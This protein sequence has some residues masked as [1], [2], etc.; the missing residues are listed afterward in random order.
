[1][2]V[3][4]Q[5]RTKR[6]RRRIRALVLT[7]AIAGAS[8]AL[9]SCTDVYG[10]GGG[11]LDI[12]WPTNGAT[13]VD[14]EVFRARVSGYDL[15]EYEIYWYVDDSREERMW[16]DWNGRSKV[17][18]EDTWFWDWRGSGPYTIGFIAEDYRGRRIA[19][20]TVRVYVR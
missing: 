17:F 18:V 12:L 20:R 1:M 9:G 4:E 5:G 16:N 7:I 6:G 11:R 8:L 19:H 13:L 14:E 15:D 3:Q 2:R 10:P